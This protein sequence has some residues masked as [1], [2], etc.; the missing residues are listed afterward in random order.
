MCEVGTFHLVFVHIILSSVWDA[1]WPSFG[2]EL[3]TRLTVSLCILTF[4]ILVTSRFSFEVGIW[5]LIAPVPG[6]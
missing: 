5:V 2:K 6:H 1:D 4:V 3:S